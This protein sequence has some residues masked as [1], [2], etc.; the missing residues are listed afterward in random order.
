MTNDL[1]ILVVPMYSKQELNGDSNYVIYTQWVQAMHRLRPDWHFVI[2][3]PDASSGF[4]Y[5]D[6][7]FFR[8][9]YVTRVPQ[10]ISPRKRANA[11]SYDAGWFDALAD[12]IAWDVVWC[13]LTEIAGHFQT[14]ESTTNPAAKPFVIAAHNYVIHETLPYGTDMQENI[15]LAQLMGAA[16]CDANVFNSDHCRWMLMDNAQKWLSQ[17]AIKLIQS[18]TNKINYG[19]LG[20]EFSLRAPA[21]DVPIIAYNHRLQDYKKWRT[22][23]AVLE[24]LHKNGVRFKVRYMNNTA[25]K[26]THIRKYPF[27]EIALSQTRS[28][29]L[30]KL[31]E[32]DLNTSNSVHETFCIAGIESMAFG[33]PL[34]APC[35]ITFPEI[36]GMAEN[37]YPYLFNNEQQQ[38]EMLQRLLIDK[39]ERQAWGAKL[40]A[41]VLQKY[42]WDKWAADYVALIESHNFSCGN[43]KSRDLTEAIKAMCKSRPQ[44]SVVELQKAANQINVGGH[45]A[46]NQALPGPRFLR[47]VRELGAKIHF[48]K[49]RQL[50]R[51]K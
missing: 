39:A 47:L 9:P 10:R 28:E 41:H 20:S 1:T 18:K 42:S 6:D 32:C 31:A 22:T 25:E 17:E 3:F 27:V 5:K 21:N 48:E 40:S 33:Q 14:T 50:L 36:T 44:A 45:Q 26:T 16:L 51:W 4:R 7:G 15:L 30:A 24:K 12:K 37:G 13:N 23:F 35:G 43:M 8:L 2:I 19:C 46:A 49:G 34:V 29:Y 38:Y 11:V